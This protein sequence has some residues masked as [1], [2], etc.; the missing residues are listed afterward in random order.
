M[1]SAVT[2]PR[3]GNFASFESQAVAVAPD[4]RIILVGSN[5]SSDHLGE[6][7][8]PTN[9]VVTRLTSTGSAHPGDF[10]GDG[11]SDP[12]VYLPSLGAFG[13]RPSQGGA[14]EI[15]PF[16]I[17]GPGQTI[18]APGDY[19][20]SGVEEIAA[21]LPNRPGIWRLPCTANGG[22]DCSSPFGTGRGPDHPRPGRLLRDRSGRRRG[23]PALARRVRPARPEGRPGPAHPV[24]DR[25]SG[26]V[27]LGAGRLRRLGKDRA[28]GLPAQPPSL[29][30]DS[31]LA[32]PP[33]RPSGSA[34]QPPRSSAG[35]FAYRP[36][37]GGPDRI[38]PFGQAG[39]GRS[40]PMPGDYDGSGKTELAVYPPSLGEFVYR[41]ANGGPDVAMAPFR[42]FRGT[43]RRSP[44]RATTRVRAG[45]SWASTSRTWETWRSGRRGVGR[46]C[47]S[48]SGSPGVARRSR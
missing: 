5:P 47:C 24:R 33:A 41:P 26:R 1:S 35:A 38:I 44:R 15:I 23:L 46:T 16:G 36:A 37:N 10:T 32:L 13:I 43:A 7:I 28:G 40:I 45:P 2:I 18:P 29:H 17:P 30:A 3:P 20:G 4:N 25:R 22:P 39:A 6:Q 14:D 21:Y 9:Y 48:R 8:F 34:R 12:A 31:P 11:I 42:D 19:T 27:D